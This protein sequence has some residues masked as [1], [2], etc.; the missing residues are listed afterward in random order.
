MNATPIRT[1][2]K[3]CNYLSLNRDS[4]VW[5]AGTD[6]ERQAEAIPYPVELVPEDP[7][8]WDSILKVSGREGLDLTAA[9][10]VRIAQGKENAIDIN[11][12]AAHINI[13]GDIGVTGVEGEQ[14]ITIKGGSHHI[15]IAGYVY[16]RGTDCDVEIGCWSD[17]STEVT[18]DVDLSR[19][20][21]HSGRSLTVVLGRVRQPWKVWLGKVPS[22][23]KLP[24]GAR[25]DVWGSI[26]EQLAWWAKRVW[27]AARYGQW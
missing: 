26:Q 24:L 3:D 11:N 19:L 10:G 6:Q 13:P 21:H 22:D 17:Q 27:V 20:A 8:A 14:V 16:S 2:T 25:L 4:V 12:R 1:A 5:Y 7:K 18:H 15:I 9:P 23:I